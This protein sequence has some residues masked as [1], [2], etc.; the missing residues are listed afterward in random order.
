VTSSITIEFPLSEIL[1]NKVDM[2]VADEA[3]LLINPG[4]VIKLYWCKTGCG[5]FLFLKM[6]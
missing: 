4:T 1:D 6:F 3:K 5:H 2:A